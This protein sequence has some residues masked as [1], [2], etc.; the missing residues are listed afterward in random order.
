MPSSYPRESVEYIYV[1]VED[2]GTP[3][4]DGVSIAVTAGGTR[5]TTFT[6]AVQTSAGLG[7]KLPGDLTPGVYRVF[8]QITA[9]DET[10]VLEVD[11]L[12]IS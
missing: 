6:P 4:T 2:A 8:V 7:Y 12:T 10:P 5:P 3:V 11:D 1:S 9:D